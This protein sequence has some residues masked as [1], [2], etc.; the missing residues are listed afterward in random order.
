[1]NKILREESYLTVMTKGLCVQFCQRRLGGAAG[2]KKREDEGKDG[3]GKENPHLYNAGF[4]IPSVFQTLVTDSLQP[5]LSCERV[6][7]ET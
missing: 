6:S 4:K 3:E 1:M 2:K 5:R 7:F